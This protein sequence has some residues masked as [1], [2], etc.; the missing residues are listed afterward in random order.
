MSKRMFFRRIPCFAILILVFSFQLS[1]A[2]FWESSPLDISNLG[3]S[4][5]N[6]YVAW[7]NNFAVVWHQNNTIWFS[8]VDENG[9]IV[10][11]PVAVYTPLN[12]WEEFASELLILEII[13]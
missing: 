11:P 13:L 5:S 1:H 6:S 10:Q 3:Q 7:G 4:A 8:R 9:I 12:L 2:Q